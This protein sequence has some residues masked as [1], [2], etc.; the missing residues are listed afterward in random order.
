MRPIF[1]FGNVVLYEYKMRS[2]L[3]GF[4]KIH[5]KKIVGIFMAMNFV[6]FAVA[7]ALACGL[8][9]DSIGLLCDGIHRILHMQYGNASLFY[10]LVIILIALPFARKNI[11]AG[12]IAYALISGYFI[13]FY[14]MLLAPLGLGDM[15][16]I[17]RFIGFFL[18][19]LSLSFGLAI[20][21]Q[22]KLGMNALDAILYKL[23]SILHVPYMALRTTTDCLYALLG[24]LMGGVFGIGTV[25]SV[26]STGFFV[27]R[28]INMLSYISVRMMEKEIV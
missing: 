15:S 9:T 25:I 10:N 27:S 23:E 1:V 11:G 24:F 18:G 3:E 20:L 5:G 4:M 19:Q 2:L 22:M 21:I 8:G 12:T 26:L 14:S 17:I 7:I 16:F 6:G 28:F 13:E